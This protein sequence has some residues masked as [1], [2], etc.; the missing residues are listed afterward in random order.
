MFALLLFVWQVMFVF[1]VQ[2]VPGVDI[3][4]GTKLTLTYKDLVAET[5][6]VL[7]RRQGVTGNWLLIAKGV[8]SELPKIDSPLTSGE[9]YFYA[10]F[11]S[12]GSTKLQDELS[13]RPNKPN[14]VSLGGDSS[15]SQ[16][17]SSEDQLPQRQSVGNSLRGSPAATD[18]STGMDTSSDNLVDLMNQIN[19]VINAIIPFLVGLAVLVIIWGVWSYISGAGDEEKRAQAKQFIV[20]GVVGVFLMLSVWGLVNILVNSFDFK[21][22]PFPSE[23]LPS[24]GGDALSSGR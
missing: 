14:S 4:N 3:T 15:V 18:S 16:G 17:N 23:K 1:A 2:V 20:W 6:Y 11:D 13:Q 21:K 22:T 12:T 5:I 24:F 7:K 9:E 19:A 8:G 10:L